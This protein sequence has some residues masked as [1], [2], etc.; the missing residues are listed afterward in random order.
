MLPTSTHPG[1]PNFS[2]YRLLNTGY[3]SPFRYNDQFALSFP[4]KPVP[5]AT[6]N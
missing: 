3:L 1:K 6:G 4:P 5:L 2:G